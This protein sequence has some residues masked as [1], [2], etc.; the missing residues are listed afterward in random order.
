M[1]PTD[2]EARQLPDRHESP[3]MQMANDAMTNYYR[4]GL[5]HI[6]YERLVESGIQLDNIGF[7]LNFA[8]YSAR[9]SEEV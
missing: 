8:N 1:N 2:R 7:L 9:L 6:T 3:H 5:A 4:G